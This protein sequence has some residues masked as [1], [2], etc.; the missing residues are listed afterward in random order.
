[1][2]LKENV[3]NPQTI[4]KSGYIMGLQCPKQLYY[5]KYA[6]HLADPVDD[7]LQ[8]IFNF[9]LE[10]SERATEIFPG[11]QLI[12]HDDLTPAQ[13]VEK[14]LTLLQQGVTTIFEAAIY[15]KGLFAR[16]DILRREGIGWAIYEVK[17]SSKAK[18]VYRNDLALQC[19]LLRT[20]GFHINKTAL[21]LL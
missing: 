1:M 16:V 14:T 10:V 18:E 5:Y 9:G 20:A 4:S 8:K 6:R 15:A 12:P 21:V 2:K 17:S 11:G 13:Q 3:L 7:K 19:H